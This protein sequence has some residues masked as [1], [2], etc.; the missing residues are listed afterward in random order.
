[1]QVTGGENLQA[2][3]S[4]V[5]FMPF[6]KT[7][8]IRG[9][10]KSTEQ[11]IDANGQT[12]AE[13]TVQYGKYG[14]IAKGLSLTPV[15]LRTK[16]SGSLLDN[17]AIEEE[18]KTHAVITVKK[19]FEPIAEGLSGKRQFMGV[20]QNTVMWIENGLENILIGALQ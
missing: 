14:R 5:N 8:V 16:P 3:L 17:F 12:L 7:E 9:I 10:R 18:S 1:M 13:Y 6:L 11:G 20:S 19:Q 4:A 2:Q 15:N